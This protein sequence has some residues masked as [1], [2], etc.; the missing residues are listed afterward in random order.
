MPSGTHTETK[1]LDRICALAAAQAGIGAQ[2]VAKGYRRWSESEHF[3]EQVRACAAEVQGY[4]WA[5][6]KKVSPPAAQGG[7]AAW[8]IGEL[9]V[10]V[11]A[12]VSTDLNAAWDFVLGLRDAL[13]NPANYGDGEFA[14]NVAVQFRGVEAVA[15]GGLAVFDF[16][17]YGSGSLAVPAL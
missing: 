15:E 9:A 1:T 4:F 10:Y 12:Q 16:G 17:A 5:A 7:H 3:Q 14:P 13:E 8:F 2:R 11:P 6:L